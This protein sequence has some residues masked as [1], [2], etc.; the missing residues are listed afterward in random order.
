MARASGL[1]RSGVRT[2]LHHRHTFV[3]GPSRL[4]L[5]ILLR[6]T[7]LAL[8]CPTLH[9][10]KTRLTRRHRRAIMRTSLQS[11]LSMVMSLVVTAAVAA[12]DSHRDI[13]ESNLN[14][15]DLLERFNK[16]KQQAELKEA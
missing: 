14:A 16:A 7:R 10:G 6:L 12:Q 1:A 8:P 3:S 5:I 4:R 9:N 15:R 11:L 2:T 13:G